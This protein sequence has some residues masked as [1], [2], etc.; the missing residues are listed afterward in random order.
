MK[1]VFCGFYSAANASLKNIWLSEATLFV[2]DTNCLLNLYR[3]EEHTREEIIDVMRELMGKTWI[4][5]QVGFEYQRNR[6]IVIEESIS[7]L[8]KIQDELKK[9]YTQNILSSGSV[10]KHLYNALSEEVS[11]LQQELQQSIDLYIKEK[12]EPRINSKKK[13]AEHDFIR[14]NID[15]II[16]ANIGN[17]PTQEHIN[18]INE[19]G[20]KRYLNKRPP[21]FK[22]ESKKDVSFFSNIEFQDKYGDLYLWKEII[23]KAKDEKIE[24]V[25]FVCDDN[26]SDWWFIHAGKTHGPLE[27]LKTEICT[28]AKIIEFR[29]INQLTFLHEAKQFLD[30]INIS[31]SS[32]KEVEEL[33]QNT[34]YTQERKNNKLYDYFNFYRPDSENTKN[35]KITKSY[36]NP[37]VEVYMDRIENIHSTISKAESIISTAQEIL[38]ETEVFEANNGYINYDNLLDTK[39]KLLSEISKLKSLTQ[40]LNGLLTDH[41]ILNEEQLTT[42]QEFS[43][44]CINVMNNTQEYMLHLK[45]YITLLS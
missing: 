28:E 44:H 43:M 25:I 18:S 20:Q 34:E 22:D 14:D 37:Y 1:S 36:D 40:A 39:L 3:C 10:K 31:D 21:G 13:I 16:G 33:S 38:E 23:E 32:L 42:A 9:I 35:K 17:I 12:I 29:L 19:L 26:K 8:N 24:N 27:A 2:F 15:D 6:R 30:N 5:F 41:T 11:T 45:A 4:P 7:S